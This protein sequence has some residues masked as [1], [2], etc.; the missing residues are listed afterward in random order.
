MKKYW[1]VI[2]ILAGLIIRLHGLGH[3]QVSLDE[4]FT[5]YHAEKS[6][7]HILTLQDPTP[8]LYLLLAHPLATTG[9]ICLVRLLSVVFGVLAIPL[10]YLIGEKLF[11]EKA[12]LYSA[13]IL[14]FSAYHAFYSQEARAYALFNFLVMLSMFLFIKY[15]DTGKY[16]IG[17]LAST[18][19]MLYSHFFALFI[20][21]TQ[22]MFSIFKKKRP[23]KWFGLQPVLFITYIPALLL[24]YNQSSRI[25]N[26]F[27][28]KKEFLIDILN[29]PGIFS[30]GVLTVLFLALFFYGTVRAYSKERQLSDNATFLLF[31]IFLPIIISS[32]YSLIVSPIIVPK[33]VIFTSIP[34]YILISYGLSKMDKR[35]VSS[36]LLAIIIISS[37]FLI[38]QA[39]RTDKERW[40]DVSDYVTHLGIEDKIIILSPGHIIHPFAYYH[41]PECFDNPEIYYCASKKGIFTVWGKENEKG[42]IR[43]N[44]NVIYVNKESNIDEVDKY[45]EYVKSQFTVYSEEDFPIDKYSHITIYWLKNEQDS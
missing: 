36:V 12:G 43:D 22:N 32:A 35:C 18:I 5:L 1:I 23:I 2:L 25:N 37:F 21:I 44:R 40:G 33:Y 9:D 4:S 30:G 15:R 26:G 13:I 41:T 7:M 28:I 11:N 39:D 29:L 16:R 20:V 42:F 17:Y 27:W 10:I 6:I 3:E 31:W 45:L 38:N 34:F 19:A 24:L 14:T 8:P